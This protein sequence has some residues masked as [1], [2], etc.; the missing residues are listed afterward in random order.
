MIFWIP[1][2]CNRYGNTATSFL[3]NHPFAKTQPSLQ[4]SAE[5]QAFMEC[6]IKN[7]T[8]HSVEEKQARSSGKCPAKYVFQGGSNNV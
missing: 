1:N 8:I 5:L 4:L 7:Y 3:V 6:C 2:S